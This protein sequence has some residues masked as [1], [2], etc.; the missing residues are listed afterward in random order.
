MSFSMGLKVDYKDLD[1]KPL[2]FSVL[3][4]GGFHECLAALT[5]LASVGA[6]YQLIAMI[7]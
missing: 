3:H 7:D 1:C 6:N 2:L 5:I 4:L